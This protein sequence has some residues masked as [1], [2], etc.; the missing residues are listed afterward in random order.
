MPATGRDTARSIA[1]RVRPAA[2]AASM[3]EYAVLQA[4]GIPRWR[5]AMAVLSQSFWVGMFGVLL[6]FPTVFAL[7]QVADTMGVRVIL[8]WWLLAGAGGVT[9]VMAML[10][11]LYAMRSLRMVEPAILLR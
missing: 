1:W 2:T 4:M 5:M 9:L 11:G 6:A 7:A 3:R 8:R 10:A